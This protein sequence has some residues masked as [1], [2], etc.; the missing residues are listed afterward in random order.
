[1]DKIKASE[2]FKILVKDSQSSFAS[3]D[4]RITMHIQKYYNNTTKD[5][6]DMI[7]KNNEY[8]RFSLI[9]T[10]VLSLCD[11]GIVEKDIDILDNTVTNVLVDEALNEWKE[12][13]EKNK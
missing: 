11:I 4:K 12:E 5:I 13:K 2:L 8:I 1:M 10:M 7:G 9:K 6:F 3:E